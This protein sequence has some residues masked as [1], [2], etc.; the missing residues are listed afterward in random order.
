MEKEKTED[1]I[2]NRAGHRFGSVRF[3]FGLKPQNRSDRRVA[4]PEPY[5]TGFLL[6]FRFFGLTRFRFGLCGFLPFLKKIV[7]QEFFK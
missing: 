7:F 3:G 5:R 4:Y 1:D 6:G 2:G